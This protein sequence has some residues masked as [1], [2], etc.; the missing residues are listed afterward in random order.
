MPTVG[1]RKFSYTP[2]GEKQAAA[3]AKKTGQKMTRK[4]PKEK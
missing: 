1:I 4:P 3:Y 2:K